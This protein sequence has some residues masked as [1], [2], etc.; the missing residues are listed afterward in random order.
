MELYIDQITIFS[1][2]SC[3]LIFSLVILEKLYCYLG[4]IKARLVEKDSRR[5]L[6]RHHYCL[7]LKAACF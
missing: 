7:V 4:R 2:A 5:T 3:F 1:I 6:F